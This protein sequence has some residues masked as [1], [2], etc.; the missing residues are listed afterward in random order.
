VSVLVGVSQPLLATLSQFAHVES[1]APSV[2]APDA[3]VAVAFARA[4]GTPHVPQSDN[5]RKDRSQPSTG[6]L[7][8]LPNAVVHAVIAQA[9]AAQLTL[10]LSRAHGAPHAPQSVTVLIAVSQPFAS[11]PSQSCRS[12]AQLAPQMPPKQSPPQH[13]QSLAQLSVSGWQLMQA[14]EVS[15]TRSVPQ[16]K[17][18]ATGV[19]PSTPLVHV[20]RPHGVP[21]GWSLSLTASTVAPPAHRLTK[22]SP[23]ICDVGGSCVPS[24]SGWYSGDIPAHASRVQKSKSSAGKSS[25]SPSMMIWP[26]PSQYAAWQSWSGSPVNKPKGCGVCMHVPPAQFGS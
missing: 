5:V 11:T 12:A 21:T 9:P 14:P 7:L 6:S 8:Q 18:A 19:V 10:A 25:E 17:P 13:S 4:Q 22:Q 26:A 3:H 23:E 15:Q 16:A 24:A 20:P 2:H 1:H